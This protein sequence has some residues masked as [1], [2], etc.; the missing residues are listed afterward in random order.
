MAKP[1]PIFASLEGLLDHGRR[2]GFD[3]RPTLLRVLT[4]LYL[5]KPAHPL[6]EERYYTE[7][8]LRLINS[9][10][11]STRT[12]VAELLARYGA[13][14]HQVI[15]RLARDVVDVAEPILRHSPCL[16]AADLDLISTDCGPAHAAIIATR[17]ASAAHG[18]G[19]AGAGRMEP[20]IDPQ[21][22]ELSELFFSADEV[23]R[24]QILLNLDYAAPLAIEL[25]PAR[26]REIV[27]KLEREALRH[28]T[29]AFTRE[30]ELAFGIASALARRIVADE[31]G[32]PIVV[33]LKALKAPRAV[34]EGILLFVNPQIGRSVA[35]LRELATRFDEISVEAA[36][37]LTAIWQSAEPREASPTPQRL[38]RRPAAVRGAPAISL[39][40]RHIDRGADRSA[41]SA[42]GVG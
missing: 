36:Q 32:E 4:D 25:A 20:G 21:A 11:L 3:F 1:P 5:Q 33:A 15:M 34:L 39:P 6:D 8:A 37:W 9:T 40:P 31:D 17:R 18:T 27:A 38:A 12:A 35:R 41:R 23:D 10:D 7:L 19:V 24:R 14:P 2:D 22:A 16:T 13:A 42:G 30:I 28:N 26:A 29:E